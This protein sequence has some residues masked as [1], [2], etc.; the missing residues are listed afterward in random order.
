M[1][2]AIG[3]SGGGTNCR[4]LPFSAGLSELV[5]IPAESREYIVTAREQGNGH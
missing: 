1:I 3:R 2:E 5:A 4:Q